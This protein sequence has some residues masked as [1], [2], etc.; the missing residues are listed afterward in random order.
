MNTSG[1]LRNCRSIEPLDRLDVSQPAGRP[2]RAPAAPESLHAGAQPTAVKM[3]CEKK[4]SLNS[5][6][7]R[8]QLVNSLSVGNKP[9][10]GPRATE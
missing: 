4:T 9:K 2:G 6:Q 3:N 5:L 1:T 7:S 8:E 10:D